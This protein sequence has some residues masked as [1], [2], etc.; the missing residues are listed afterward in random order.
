[1]LKIIKRILSIAGKE[2]KGL[3]AGVVVN[4]FENIAMFI[5]YI[6]VFYFIS[7]YINGTLSK[8]SIFTVTAIMFISII[9]RCVL[10]RIVDGLQSAKGLNIFARQR[11]KMVNH[12]RKLP[13]GYFSEG[14]IGNIISILTTDIIFMEE[15]CM[16][17]FGQ[18]MSAFIGLGLTVIFMIYLNIWLGLSFI[19]I[20]IFAFAAIKYLDNINKKFG[21]V[22]QEQFGF[23][24]KSVVQ[25]IRGIGTIK[26][27]GME[28]EKNID[29]ES[30][31]EKS[32][33][34]A[35]SFEKSYLLPRILT[36]SSYSIGTALTIFVA[37]LLYFNG[38]I[39]K[40]Y[41]L[42]ILIFAPIA[43]NSIMIVINGVS[44]F[45]ILEAGLDR[46]DDVMKVSELQ[47]TEKEYELSNLDIEFNNVNFAYEDKEILKNLS[48]TIPEKTFAALIGPSGSGKSTITNL[49]ARFWDIKSG[50]I[51]LGGVN[52]KDM[53]V[54]TLLSKISMVFQDVYLFEDTIANNIAFGSN[55][56]NKD[57]IIK[58]AKKARC[59]EFI[60]ELK[61]GYDT[62]INEAGCNLSGGQKQRI[63]IARAILKDAP[64]ILLDE[65]T[66]S[67]DPE[68][69][70]Y[71]Q[72]AINELVKNKTLIVIAHRLS[73][74][75]DADNIFV[76]DNGQIC[77]SGNH[78]NLIEQNGVYKK[79]WQYS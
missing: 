60:T 34:K 24:S 37:L 36:E 22:R 43:F 53:S 79:L 58:A 5:P 71:I 75:K 66:S 54:N 55:N 13:M 61:D 52:I 35:I 1:M 15:T 18:Y 72:Q 20:L 10:R 76:I 25:F 73:S 48:L 46:Y 70:L 47:D 31:F 26:A 27:F 67:V 59:H 40:E 68:N 45:G 39:N 28:N 30:T 44:R 38:L 23:L 78:D 74:V 56:V 51:S 77:E 64:I 33:D 14:N 17:F 9:L 42:G 6:L 29:L 8:K 32:R 49:I 41:I 62:I 69:E 50:L 2:K 63:S 12:L 57:D 21:A 3:L 65:A 16:T 7:N 11:I 19:V 4:F